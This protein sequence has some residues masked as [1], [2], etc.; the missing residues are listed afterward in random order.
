MEGEG[1]I[2]VDQLLV[3]VFKRVF[4][5]QEKFA[6]S[7]SVGI[8]ELARVVWEHELLVCLVE[9]VADVCG[10]EA[11]V[12]LGDPSFQ[13]NGDVVDGGDRVVCKLARVDVL[14]QLGLDEVDLFDGAVHAEEALDGVVAA[15]EVAALVHDGGDDKGDAV[16]LHGAVGDAELGVDVLGDLGCEVGR[17]G[18][19]LR[20]GEEPGRR[21]RLACGRVCLEVQLVRVSRVHGAG[22]MAATVRARAAVRGR[23]GGLV[24]TEGGREGPPAAGERPPLRM[25]EGRVRVQREGRQG[26]PAAVFL[27]LVFAS[28]RWGVFLF[29]RVRGLGCESNR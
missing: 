10:D 1:L 3:D 22:G 21:P 23:R 25:V 9:G 19:E 24:E 14:L 29:H 7:V 6:V 18:R 26:P 20:G 11:V 28:V 16:E 27:L 5:F 2:H 13:H 15:D 4:C 12:E 8:L 17:R